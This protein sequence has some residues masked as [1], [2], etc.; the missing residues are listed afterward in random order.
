MDRGFCDPVING[1]DHAVGLG[2]GNKF[3]RGNRA[4]LSA[5]PANQGFI[6]RA[7]LTTVHNGLV[8]DA[9]L[10]VINGRTQVPFNQSHAAGVSFQSLVKHRMLAFAVAFGLVHRHVGMAQ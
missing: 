3:A 6:T 2:D 5:G 1:L 4:Q 7:T 9:Q 8:F 10:V